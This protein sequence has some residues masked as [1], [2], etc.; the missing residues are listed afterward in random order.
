MCLEMDG[1]DSEKW[2]NVLGQ[3]ET[4][5]LIPNKMCLGRGILI[6]KPKFKAKG[7]AI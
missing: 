6:L 1:Y 7:N 5:A 3:G 4:E 2:R